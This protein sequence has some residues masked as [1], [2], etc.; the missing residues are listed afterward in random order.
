MNMTPIDTVKIACG[1]HSLCF[2][3]LLLWT[4]SHVFPSSAHAFE[5]A[6]PK[7]GRFHPIIVRVAK[8]YRVETELVKAIIRVE[9]GYDAHAVSRNGAQGLMQ[10]MPDT[11]EAL[12][13]R[14]CF[15]PA[16]NIDAGVRYFN[17]LKKQFSGNIVLA[18][19]AYNAGPARVRKCGGI[20]ELR[21]TRRYILKVLDFYAV[22]KQ[23]GT[24]GLHGDNGHH[25]PIDRGH[26]Q[27]AL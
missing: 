11:A 22:Y 6:K 9:S 24:Q 5:D 16:Q 1:R 25:D 15:D 23:A 10:L 12:G 21:C 13:V 7:Q 4:L 26:L 3:F 17:K 2:V 14:D 27:D 20:P 8:K 19:A 18:L